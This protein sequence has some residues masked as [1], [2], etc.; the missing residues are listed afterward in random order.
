MKVAIVAVPLLLLGCSDGSKDVDASTD[1]EG[2]D[3]VDTD[4][5]PPESGSTPS[6]F[7]LVTGTCPPGTQALG[8][9]KD[10]SGTRLVDTEAFTWAYDAD[11]DASYGPVVYRTVDD[12]VSGLQ[13]T[14]EGSRPTSIGWAVLAGEVLVDVTGSTSYGDVVSRRRGMGWIRNARRRS[15][16]GFGTGST[17]STAFTGSAHTGDT[18]NYGSLEGFF[19]EPF[20]T[21][22]A[23]NGTLSLP[24]GP[25]TSPTAGCLAMVPVT[26]GHDLTGETAE[27]HFL[28]QRE[29]EEEATVYLNAFVVDG[30]DITED[31]VIEAIERMNE[32]YANGDAPQAADVAFFTVTSPDGPY[33]PGRGATLNALRGSS[34]EGAYEGAVNLLFISDFSDQSGTLGISAGL[35]GPTGINGLAGAA[36]TLSVESHL[37][38]DG[39]LLISMLGETI[40]HE[41]GHQM[42]LFH[43]T[44]ATGEGFDILSDTS[45]CDVANHP[46]VSAEEC[47]ALDGRNF[48]FWT[49]GSFAQDQVTPQQANVILNNVAIY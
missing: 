15:D 2:T 24:N 20:F 29:R 41:L 37:D 9:G 3:V 30:V 35:P 19:G 36:V 7:P 39:E 23:P 1:P 6:D 40:A 44:E 33:I 48:M 10:E 46:N 22:P 34:P 12:T 16:T 17:A 11:Y 18:A 4:A 27:V 26:P 25:D 13:V 32:V 38:G 43:T 5:S 45:E 42:G 8:A 14:I 47:E 49:S 31:Q 21:S 28:A